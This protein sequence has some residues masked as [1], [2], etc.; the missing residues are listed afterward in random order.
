MPIYVKTTK[1]TQWQPLQKIYVKTTQSTQWQSVK[2]AFV[3][4]FGGWVQ[5]WPKSG[6]YTTKPPYFSTDTAGNVEPSGYTL[7]VN[8]TIYLQKGTWDGNG[9]TI[10][11]YAYK[12]YTATTPT[13]AT[14]PYQAPAAGSLINYASVTLDA[15][16]YD[17][18]YIIGN[19]TA[20]RSDGVQGED[21]TDSQGY[22][23]FVMRKYAPSPGSGSITSSPSSNTTTQTGGILLVRGAPI[24]FT[25]TNNWNGTNNYLPDSTRS[26][27]KWYSSTNGTYTTASQVETNGTLITSG[28]GS[29][30]PSSDGTYYQTYVTLITGNTIPDGTY[31]YV[32]DKQYNSYT[33]YNDYAYADGV[34]SVTSI[35][36]IKTSPTPTVQPTLTATTSPS[37]SGNPNSFTVGSTITGNTGS[38][39]PAVN[40]NYPVISSFKYSS[41]SSITNQSNWSLFYTN[42][43]GNTVGMIDQYDNTNHSFILPD[44]FYSGPYGGSLG[45]SIGKYIEYLVSA[46]NGNGANSS[47]DFITNSQKV[48]AAPHVTNLGGMTV[49]QADGSLSVTSFSFPDSTTSYYYQLQYAPYGGSWTNMGS[50]KYQSTL[51]LIGYAA[52]LSYAA[53][54]VPV[55]NYYYRVLAYN[56][57]GVYIASS[58]NYGPVNTVKIPTNA[59]APYWTDTSNNSISAPYVVGSTY[60]LH[61]GTWNNNPTYYD[62]EVY[63]DGTNTQTLTADYTGTYTQNYVDYTFNAGTGTKKV[64]AFVYAGNSGGISNVAFPAAIGPITY[65]EPTVLSYP[66]ISGSGAATSNIYFSGGS[67]SNGSLQRTD[68]IASTNN[69]FS[70]SSTTKSTLTQSMIGTVNTS[71]L[72][73]NGSLQYTIIVSSISGIVANTTVVSGSYITSGSIVTGISGSGPYTLT[74][75]KHTGYTSSNTQQSVYLT[76]TNSYYTVTNFDASGTPYRFVTRD[77]VLGSNGNTYYYYSGGYSTTS[78]NTVNI[79]NGSGAILSYLLTMSTYPTYGSTTP[80]T[81]GFTASVN[82]TP[83][84][85]GGIYSATASSGSV[86]INSSTGAFTVT[87]LSSG[88]SSTV[89]V[90]YTVTNYTPVNI[91][92]SGN[93]ITAPGAFTY[94]A[95]D[96]TVTPSW[97]SGAGISISGASNNVMTVTWNAAN[98]ATSYADQV[99]G[100]YNST[101]FNTGT[102]RSDTWGYSSSGNEYATVYAYNS[103]QQVTLAWGTSTN[104]VSYFYSY[105]VGATFYSGS[106]TSNSITFSVPASTT[107]TIGGVSAWTGAGATGVGTAGTLQ[108]GYSSTVT[109]SQKSTSASG[110]PFYLTYTNPYYSGSFSGTLTITNSGT[111]LT[112]S[113]ASYTNGNPSATVN[114]Y[115]NAPGY[116]TYHPNSS[117]YTV[118]SGDLGTTI[119]AYEYASNASWPTTTVYSNTA[120]FAVPGLPGTPTGLSNTYAGGTSYTFSWSASTNSSTYVVTP[121]HATSSAGAGS[122]AKPSF[123]VSG[124]STSYNSA[125]NGG[126]SSTYVSFKVHGVNSLGFSG[127]DSAILTPY[128]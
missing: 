6:P 89:T 60:R 34:A 61:F 59:T 97:P 74:L 110:G 24:S 88:A 51:S 7:S 101:L 70:S 103:S 49:S 36:P 128:H 96:S 29:I 43:G 45:S 124:T 2:K 53:A 48:H 58:S 114:Y 80:T 90:T 95:Y 113:G 98:N 17:G 120:Y 107:V 126:T 22:R 104:A 40:G 23:Y 19:I 28:T 111:T 99:S 26:N 81:D 54:D 57:D 56:D 68:L 16:T 27:V 66:S 20:T 69:T 8:S 119:S 14:G 84:P 63:L 109:P 106:T 13:L 11:S 82:N 42:G 118:T 94:Y 15:G 77:T 9:G 31:Y 102:N 127:S 78:T 108:S 52:Y 117:T 100:V 121:Y 18:K 32:V 46:E 85:S 67:Y 50:I 44:T 35:G 91:T 125:T 12:I 87:G 92:V 105:T 72:P 73:G 38:W 39:S 79:S 62:Y 83:N 55:G 75:N 1:S 112:M 71:A 5:F 37:Y 21:S 86:S 93:A 25:Y 3:K 47:S 41:S 64:Q 33:D 10:S 76:F 122:T 30:S 65:P 115:W 116:P 4:A 123:T